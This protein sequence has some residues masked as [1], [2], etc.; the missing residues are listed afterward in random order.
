MK[1]FEKV[2]KEA[3][4]NFGKK[5]GKCVI[6]FGDID[7]KEANK[8]KELRQKT[9]LLKE[10]AMEAWFALTRDVKFGERLLKQ[11]IGREEY[12]THWHSFHFKDGNPII[13]SKCFEKR[14][15]QTSEKFKEIMRELGLEREHSLK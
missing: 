2:F 3:K 4:I 5:F 11:M 8:T 1:E 12:Y 14:F 15:H 13:C 9:I 7:E 10:E 6:C